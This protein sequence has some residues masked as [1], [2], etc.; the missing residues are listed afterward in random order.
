MT[1]E[2]LETYLSVNVEADGPIPGP[3]SML[4]IGAVA[5]TAEEGE[6]IDEYSVK[7]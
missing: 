7:I 6:L 3:Y 1:N 2:K 4:S 5:Y